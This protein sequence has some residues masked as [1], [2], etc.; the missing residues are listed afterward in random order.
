LTTA[1]YTGHHDLPEKLISKHAHY[2]LDQLFSTSRSWIQAM[3]VQWWSPAG[4]LL[5]YQENKLYFM[6]WLQSNP[7]NLLIFKH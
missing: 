2:Y 6:H 4:T 5:G 7:T 1:D 3:P